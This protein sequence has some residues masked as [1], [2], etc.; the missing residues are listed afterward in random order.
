MAQIKLA[1]FD[2]EDVVIG[3]WHGFNRLIPDIADMSHEKLNEI[4]EGEKMREFQYGKLSEAEFLS[5]IKSYSGTKA[6]TAEIQ[7]AIRACQAELPGTR[8]ILGELR[9]NGWKLAFLSNNGKEWIDYMKMRYGL[10]KLV[11]KVYVSCYTGIKKPNKEAYLQ[12]AKDF[13]VQ[14]SECLFIDDKERNAKGAIEAGM[15]AFVYKGPVGLYAELT[16]KYGARFSLPTHIFRSYDV[17]GI[18][19]LD[20]DEQLAIRIGK[21]FGTYIGAGKKVCV[22]M[23][24]RNGGE[25]LKAAFVQGV[26]SVGV[27]VI[28]LGIVSTPIFYFSIVHKNLDGGAMVTASHNPPM[29]N[30]F[31]LCE[32]GAEIV[33]EG[34]GMERLKEIFTKGE[35]GGGHDGSLAKSEIIPDYGKHVAEKA[36]ITKR[37]K[38]VVDPGNGSWCRIAADI[39]RNMGCDVAEING[40]PDPNFTAR[41]PDPNYLALNGLKA[42]VLKRSADFGVGFDS[43]GDR[44]GFIDDKGRFVGSASIIPIFSSYVLGKR[45]GK[46]IYD[47][48]CTS[49]IEEVVRKSGGIPIMNRTGHSH[50]TSRMMEESAVFGAEYSNHI[51]FPENYNFD[52]GCFAA[53]KMG[54]VVSSTGKSLSQLVDEFPIYPAVPIEEV[55]CP[56]ELKFKVVENIK[57]KFRSSG[58]D[59]IVDIDGIKAFKGDGWVLVRAS[60][61]MPQVKVN[62]E[63]RTKEEAKELFEF[64]KSVLID[65][66]SKNI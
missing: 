60:N 16:S 31:K 66:I 22:G 27:D 19:K 50:I 44:A 2:I 17:R 12:V 10:H 13:G 64:G 8:Y 53:L 35:F 52:D 23:D 37:L 45:K 15:N 51:Y 28:D 55:Y 42:E 43:D 38:V 26:R 5:W 63:A 3:S 7:N 29:W 32:K 34:R 61:T 46:V 47:V 18:Y 48:P 54:E 41:G 9:K 4:T 65:E 30:G 40:N 49:V 25:S 56:D 33:S 59:K 57:P 20:L 24:Y 14:P 11:E 1:I 21:S 58:F 6:S 39:F 36:R 62:S